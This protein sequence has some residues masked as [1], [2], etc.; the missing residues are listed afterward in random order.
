MWNTRNSICSLHIK[1]YTRLQNSTRYS[2]ELQKCPDLTVTGTHINTEAFLACS[3]SFTYSIITAAS[4]TWILPTSS[5]HRE[6]S[7]RRRLSNLKHPRIRPF[8]H[9]KLWIIAEACLPAGDLSQPV[10]T[11]FSAVWTL[12]VREYVSL[13]HQEKNNPKNNTFCLVSFDPGWGLHA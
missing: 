8:G 9:T 7:S 1:F 3:F 5:T 10:K 11:D 13:V 12:R 6:S 4:K 2:S